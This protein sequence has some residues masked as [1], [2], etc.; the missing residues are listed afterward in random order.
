MLQS[1]CL[2]PHNIQA[3]E[4]SEQDQVEQRYLEFSR[5]AANGEL[6]GRRNP[7]GILRPAELHYGDQIF[8]SDGNPLVE[9]PM[10]A[11]PLDLQDLMPQLRNAY[12]SKEAFLREKGLEP[13]FDRD[14]NFMTIRIFRPGMRIN[15]HDFSFH[16]RPSE[17]T[18]I[19]TTLGAF[20]MQTSYGFKMSDEHDENG[21]RLPIAEPEEGTPYCEDHK[22]LWDMYRSDIISWEDYIVGYRGMLRG[23][24]LY[25]PMYFGSKNYTY[26]DGRDQG[27]VKSYPEP[28]VV[29]V[30]VRKI[31]SD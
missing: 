28:K 6:H 23:S 3:T 19:L 9:G 26:E 29:E 1:S 30:G 25:E 22:T 18:M 14:F 31:F 13:N 8:D 7:N 4:M 10:S 11:L 5:R 27:F 17:K 20:R 21:K 16:G 24:G 15:W 12:R 2:C